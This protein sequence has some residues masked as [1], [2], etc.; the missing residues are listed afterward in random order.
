MQ[1]FIAKS[2]LLLHT[3]QNFQ[4]LNLNTLHVAQIACEHGS[5]LAA[6]VYKQYIGAQLLMKYDSD[7]TTVETLSNERSG[8]QA[9]DHCR[10]WVRFLEV[11]LTYLKNKINWFLF[12]VETESASGSVRSRSFHCITTITHPQY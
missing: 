7:S 1:L 5:S 9:N 8:T 3:A 11:I 2:G 10:E 4:L 6:I 12:I